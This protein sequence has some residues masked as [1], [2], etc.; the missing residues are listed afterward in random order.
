MYKQ[1]SGLSEEAGTSGGLVSGSPCWIQMTKMEFRHERNAACFD[2][3]LLLKL[4][5]LLQNTQTDIYTISEGQN[6]LWG[7]VCVKLRL[8]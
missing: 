7:P 1:D 8:I 5:H 3:A 6:S 4:K 2:S